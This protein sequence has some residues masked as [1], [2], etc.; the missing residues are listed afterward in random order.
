MLSYYSRKVSDW[1]H[2]PIVLTNG[3][4]ILGSFLIGLLAAAIIYSKNDLKPF[5]NIGGEVVLGQGGNPPGLP[6]HREGGLT[7]NA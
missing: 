5:S 7:D 4:V 6:C 3:K 1:L 2:Q